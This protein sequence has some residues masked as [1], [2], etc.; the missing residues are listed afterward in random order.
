MAVLNLECYV[1]FSFVISTNP[2]ARAVAP[3]LVFPQ[4]SLALAWHTAGTRAY[5]DE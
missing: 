5:L 1:F 4:K 3:A 2:A